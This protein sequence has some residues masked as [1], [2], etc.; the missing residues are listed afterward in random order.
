MS[1]MRLQMQCAF[2]FLICQKEFGINWSHKQRW[3]LV[4]TILWSSIAQTPGY[5]FFQDWLIF[6]SKHLH[7]SIDETFLS[8]VEHLFSKHLYG[9]CLVSGINAMCFTNIDSFNPIQLYLIRE[10][11]MS[12]GHTC[13]HKSLVWFILFTI[14]QTMRP[15]NSSKFRITLNFQA[16]IYSKT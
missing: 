7:R 10:T 13:F 6:Q 14:H 1:R 11:S 3:Q 5:P 2:C 12:W 15:Q 16:Q 4:Y 9:I 8:S